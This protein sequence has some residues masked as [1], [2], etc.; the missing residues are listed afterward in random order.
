MDDSVTNFFSKNAEQNYA[1]QY[2]LDHGPRLDQMIK[3]WLLWEYCSS[4]KVLDVGGGLGF[5][6]KRLTPDV[7]YHVL[8]GAHV[9]ENQRVCAGKWHVCD[10]D[11]DRF[12]SSGSLPEGGQFDM[13]FCLETLEHLTNPYNCLAEMKKLVKQDGD[14]FISI[15]H[16]N[17]TH[18][19]IYPGLMVDPNAF[20]QFLG[21]MALPVKHYFLWDKGWNAHHF[22]CKNRPYSEKVMLFPKQEAKF[23]HATPVEMVNW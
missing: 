19:Y 14:I 16:F 23:F 4:K 9:E 2:D 18:N 17:V 22:W 13:A 1:I 5:L 3:K 15:P 11:Y 12:S 10:L 20:A 7:N 6:G 21:Q 8:D